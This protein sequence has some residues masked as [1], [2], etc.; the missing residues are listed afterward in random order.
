V[1]NA[2]IILAVIVINYIFNVGFRDIDLN[3]SIVELLQLFRWIQVIFMT[4]LVYK[5]LLLTLIN[6]INR[7]EIPF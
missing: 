4:E 1:I 5:K 2:N 3:V 6:P 7:D